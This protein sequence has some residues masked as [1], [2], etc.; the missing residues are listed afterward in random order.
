MKQTLYDYYIVD[1]AHRALRVTLPDDLCH[2]YSSL[3]ISGEE[4]M[5]R[6]FEYLTSLEEPRIHPEEAIVMLRTVANLPDVYTP[7]E[8]ERL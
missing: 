3:G 1:R 2:T 5:T 7:S 4:R 6:R 8:W